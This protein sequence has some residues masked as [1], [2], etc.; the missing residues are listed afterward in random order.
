MLKVY[1]ESPYAGDIQRNE[2]YAKECVIDSLLRGEAPFASHLFYTQKGI[3]NDEVSYERDMGILAG[4]AWAREADIIAIYVDN[5]ISNGMRFGIEQA[6]LAK[7]KIEYR[8]IYTT[9]N[10]SRGEQNV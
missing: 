3:L 5:G 8:R 9:T 2:N 1:I 7:Q 4:Q 6:V 10:D